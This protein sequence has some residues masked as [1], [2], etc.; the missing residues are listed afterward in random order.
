MFRRVGCFAV[1]TVILCIVGSRSLFY[2]VYD[3]SHQFL[4]ATIHVQVRGGVV[5]ERW[6]KLGGGGGGGKTNQ[7]ETYRESEAPVILYVDNM[8]K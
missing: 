4:Q 3:S 8:K 6:Q 5:K 1:V 2:P 7:M